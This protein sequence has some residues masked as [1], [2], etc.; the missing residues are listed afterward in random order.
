MSDNTFWIEPRNLLDAFISS[1]EKVMPDLAET[2]NHYLN[3]LETLKST[4]PEN[5]ATVD[6]LHA[7]LD[8]R[9]IMDFLF[10]LN[11][12]YQ[13]NLNYFKDPVHHNFLEKDWDCFL[14]ENRKLSMARRAETVLKFDALFQAPFIHESEASNYII[15]YTSYIDTIIPKLAHFKG[16]LLAND[17]L[18]FTEPGYYADFMLTQRYKRM[19]R[20]FFQANFLN[21]KPER[22]FKTAQ[23]FIITSSAG[24]VRFHTPHPEGD[25]STLLRFPR[26][27][28]R[29]NGAAARSRYASD[30]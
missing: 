12:G 9:I 4:H 18:Y 23:V 5:A 8:Q 27:F 21:K 17:L 20:D 15:E 11:L 1:I 14:M 26:S 13:D 16:H 22:C 30:S 19:I 28:E 25:Q 6:Q 2:K 10:E 7:L 24:A 29:W 3:A